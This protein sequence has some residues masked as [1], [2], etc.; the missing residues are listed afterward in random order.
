MVVAE[1][2]RTVDD[3]QRDP[4]QLLDKVSET[5][6]PMVITMDG[7]PAALLLSTDLFPSKKVALSAACELTDPG[8]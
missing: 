3:L 7:K 8:R 1:D 6:R 4:K 5:R 2:I